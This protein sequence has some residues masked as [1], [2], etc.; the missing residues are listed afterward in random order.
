M[1]QSTSPWFDVYRD[2]DKNKDFIKI[3]ESDDELDTFDTINDDGLISLL[4]E[5]KWDTSF[6]FTE[7]P[8]ENFALSDSENLENP[9]NPKQQ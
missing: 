8:D 9:E 7:Q 1:S 3:I 5:L 2:V 4:E 6:E